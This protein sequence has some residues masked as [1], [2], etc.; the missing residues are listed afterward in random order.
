MIHLIYGENLTIIDE[1]I[2]SI[3]ES[4]NNTPFEKVKQTVSLDEL[5]ILCSSIDMFS[6][7]KGWLIRD[8]KWLKKSDKKEQSKL[9]ELLNVVQ[10]D[11]IPFIVLTKTVDKRSASYKQF[12]ALKAN[13]I[14]CDMF[15]DWEIDKMENWILKYCKKHNIQIEKPLIKQLING[16]GGNLALIKQEL[17]KLSITIYPKEKIESNDLIHSSSNSFGVYNLLSEAIANGKTN[18]I[19][20]SINKLIELKEDPHKII[21]QILFQ[22]NN[23]LPISIGMSM[24][25]NNDQIATKLNKHPFFIK[26]QMDVLKK[27][28]LRST[29]PIIIKEIAELDS[30]L[31][32]GKL[33]GKHALIKL[34][35]N[36]KHQ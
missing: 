3:I 33:S 12:K 8:P 19:I 5:F 35:N 32:Q 10:Q 25:L 14:K 36:I 2:T 11:N 20:K 13:E 26:K 28:K 29:F 24:Q 1:E 34:S 22:I 6:P 17:S 30:L 31:K 16:Y 23:L 9:K 4:S 18:A 7:K 27:N 15:K 21:N